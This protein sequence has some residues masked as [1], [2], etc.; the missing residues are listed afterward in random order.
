MIQ[1]LKAFVFK[2]RVLQQLYRFLQD[3]AQQLTDT[4]ILGGALVKASFP[5]ANA[6]VAVFHNLNSQQVQCLPCAPT[7]PGFIYQSPNVSSAPL[8][9][10]LLRSSTP[11]MTCWLWF[12]TT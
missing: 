5:T 12:F 1:G 3:W 7:G 4:Q 11:G 2:E 8:R 6:D 9:S 10:M